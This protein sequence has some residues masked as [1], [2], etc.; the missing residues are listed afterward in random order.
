MN[1][2]PSR[3][4]VP[5]RPPRLG[6]VTLGLVLLAA[7][8]AAD[9]VPAPAPVFTPKSA[10]AFHVDAAGVSRSG[11]WKLMADRAPALAEQLKSLPGAPVG[12]P[13]D[14]PS[15]T[16]PSLTNANLVEIAVSA[17]PESFLEGLE[18]GKTDPAAT[19]LAAVRF[20][21]A[22]NADA[23]MSELL[24]AMETENPGV[25]NQVMASRAKVGPADVYTLPPELLKDSN[26]TFPVTMAIGPGEE[27]TVLGLG[28][29]EAVQDFVSGRLSG[30][31]PVKVTMLMPERRLAWLY[32]P[33][34]AQAMKDLTASQAGNP[35]MAGLDQVR[36]FGLNLGFSDSSLDLELVLGFVDVDAPQK[37]AQGLQGFIGMMQMMA[38]QNPSASP[39][40]LA[41][42]KLAAEGRRL[43]LKTAVSKADLEQAMNSAGAGVAGS[44][45]R[46]PSV[47]IPRSAPLAEPVPSPV[48]LEFLRMLPGEGT[49]Y[50]RGRVRVTNRAA[51]AVRDVE[52]TFNYVD[53]AGRWLGRWK[54]RQGD[55]MSDVLVGPGTN[56]TVE[57]QLFRIPAGMT[58]VNFTIHEVLFTDGERWRPAP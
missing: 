7:P 14:F 52:A 2:Y 29:A 16:M 28:R 34:A 22:V 13:A 11:I 53:G 5:P 20:V 33:V 56:R 47:A 48:D 3:D 40:A 41:G 38:A 21:P 36:E 57:C 58:S 12:I 10:F 35:M 44:T 32:V 6:L 18:A 43:V 51:K 49:D 4:P 39:K 31:L 23:L 9:F 42:L 54:Q 25:S 1:R 8:R 27:G 15:M 46:Q 30:E 19:F 50:R 17:G 37:M 45:A 26:L 55:L 24:A